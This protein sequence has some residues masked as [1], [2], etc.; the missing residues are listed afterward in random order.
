MQKKIRLIHR[1]RKRRRCVSYITTGD[2]G[3]VG[4][5]LET[6]PKTHIPETVI[7][8]DTDTANDAITGEIIAEQGRY[9]LVKFNEEDYQCMERRQDGRYISHRSFESLQQAEFHF[10]HEHA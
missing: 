10:N 9:R 6:L 1:N 4:N 8:P 2:S 7:L 3:L 5:A